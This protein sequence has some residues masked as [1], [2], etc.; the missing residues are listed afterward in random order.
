MGIDEYIKK[1]FL[2]LIL[3]SLTPM[4]FAAQA[5]QFGTISPNDGASVNMGTSVSFECNYQNSSGSHISNAGGTI[6][7]IEVL[8]GPVAIP[9]IGL[10]ETGT[11]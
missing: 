1:L 10:G 2:F 5:T 4:V 6:V 8:S 9:N 7:E 3:V 11:T